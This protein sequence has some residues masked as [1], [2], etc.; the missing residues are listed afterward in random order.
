MEFC[1]SSATALRGSDCERA[2]Q[3][4]RSNGSAGRR[5]S[6]RAVPLGT[7]SSVLRARSIV[8]LSLGTRCRYATRVRRSPPRPQRNDL[9][10]SATLALESTYVRAASLHRTPST[11]HVLPQAL[12]TQALFTNSLH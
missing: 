1:T 3:R 4:I 6:V 8:Q 11:D 7:A 10:D 12:S 5:T 9:P 2:S